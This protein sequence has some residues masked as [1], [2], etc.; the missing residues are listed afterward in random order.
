MS[1]QRQFG[2][3]QELG[4]QLYP[5]ALAPPVESTEAPSP[6]DVPICLPFRWACSVKPLLGFKQ[7]WS[8]REARSPCASDKPKSVTRVIRHTKKETFISP[9]GEG[10]RSA[11]SERTQATVS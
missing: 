6:E 10:Q 3:L 8:K 2:S 11:L 4:S 9:Q 7:L 5:A 1:A